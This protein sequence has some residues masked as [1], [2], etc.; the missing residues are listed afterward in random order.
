MNIEK[1]LCMK[2]E[3]NEWIKHGLFVNDMTHASTRAK[4]TRQ[5]IMEYKGEF[6]ITFKDL[7]TTFLGMEVEQDQ[8]IIGLNLDT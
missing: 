4:I 1:A 5:F 7:V 2:R 3:N 8:E 6:E